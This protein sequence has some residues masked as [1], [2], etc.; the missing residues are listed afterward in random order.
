MSAGIC[1]MNKSAIALAADSA[2]TVGNHLAVHNSANKLFALSK[3]APVG[4]IMYAS[5]NFMHVPFEVIVKQ[6]KF[7]L[8]QKTFSKLEEYVQDFMSYISDN[9]AYF[10]FTAT[11]EKYIEEVCSDFC[12]GFDGDF[13][14]LYNRAVANKQAPLNES[15]MK[16]LFTEVLAASKKF[17]EQLDELD[18]HFYDYLKKTYENKIQEFLKQRYNWIGV[19]EAT[20]LLELLLNCFDRDFF[21]S[22]YTGLAFSGYGDEEMYPTLVHIHLAGVID[23]HP[24]MKRLQLES[25]SDNVASVIVP[26]AQTDVMQTFMFGISDKVLGSIHQKASSIL[27]EDVKRID[28]KCFVQGKRGEVEA[29]LRESAQRITDEVVK[30]A[31]EESWAPFYLA[32]SSLTITDLSMLAE[33]MINITSFRRKVALDRNIDT[34]GGPID[35][36]VISKGDGFVWI[37]RKHYFSIDNNLQY[38]LNCLNVQK[39]SVYEKDSCNE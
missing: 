10:Q 8:K 7:N 19:E 35:V 28:D 5:A 31:V 11:E 29:K 17:I 6:Y 22:G 12:D 38:V 34:V 32:A 20:H 21:R 25:V 16:E 3:S 26:L 30:E 15:E 36:A 14:E 1:V 37:K 4:V 13:K 27:D 24:R 39:E 9:C 23:C 2:V 18:Y 33:S